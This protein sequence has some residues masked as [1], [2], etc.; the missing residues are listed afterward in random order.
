MCGLLMLVD[1]WLRSGD[2]TAFYTDKGISPT[3]ISKYQKAYVE[4][5]VSRSQPWHTVWLWQR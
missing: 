3:E 2:L 1:I 5:L 4:V